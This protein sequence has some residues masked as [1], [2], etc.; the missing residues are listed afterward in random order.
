MLDTS[1]AI[2]EHMFNCFRE[3]YAAEETREVVEDRFECA[4]VIPENDEANAAC[5]A[6]ISTEEILSAIRSGST[7]KAPGAD[8]VPIEFYL[9]TFD[10]IHRELNLMLNEALVREIPAEFVAGTIVLAKK[11]GGDDTAR[12]YRPISLLNVDY[13]I[14]SCIMKARLEHVVRT[15][16]LLNDAQKCSN[17]GRSIFQATLSLKDK[18][19]EMIARKRRGKFISFDLDHAFD[20]VSHS[21]LQRTMASMGVHPNFVAL[22]ARITERASSRLMVNGN[23]SQPFPIER[24]V[25]QGD[26]MSLLLFVLYLHPFLARLELICGD[27]LCVAYADDVTVITTSTETIRLIYDLFRRFE[28]AAG[29]KLN[30][31]KTV[32]IDVGDMNRSPLVVPWLQTAEKVKVL[33]IIFVNSIRLMTR[34]NWDA[35]VSKLAQQVWLHSLRALTLIQ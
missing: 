9:R 3:L 5:V 17:P 1:E 23:L 13:K 14:M 21:F 35:L 31:Q 33:G 8:G 29:A 18:V 12:A 7:R 20:R 10:V 2:E 32:A 24:S 15:H 30:V 11:R 27:D 16:H 25:R 4:R 34:L 28:L 26:P 19:A 6:E 22:V